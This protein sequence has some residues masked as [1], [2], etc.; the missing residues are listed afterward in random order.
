LG[1]HLQPL[2]QVS[3]FG[4]GGGDRNKAHSA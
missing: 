2:G 3:D 1:W 4:D